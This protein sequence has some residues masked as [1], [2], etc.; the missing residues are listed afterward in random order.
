MK[1]IFLLFLLI[2]A[3]YFYFYSG[4]EDEM[5]TSTLLTQPKLPSGAK[6]LVLLRE[7]GL[8][9]SESAPVVAV[10]AKNK[11]VE[12]S[13]QSEL[14]KQVEKIAAP[15]PQSQKAAP[16]P[17]SQKK[18]SKSAA[19]VCF[20]LGPF[21]KARLAD[22]AITAANALSVKVVLRKASQRTPKGY[23]VY[24]A[25]SKT[26]KAA[27]R[28]VA[29]LKKKGLTDL[30]IMGNGNRKNAISLGLFKNKEVAEDRLKQVKGMGLKG[31]F[32][33][34]YQVSEQL[35]LDMSV[36]GNKTATVAALTEL[37]D[38]F[39]TANLTQRKCQLER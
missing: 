31:V 38:G 23:W 6:P 36:A 17:Q 3:A 22:R 21:T 8:R 7:R 4:A 13:A 26:Y 34:Q 28:K 30:F 5:V 35:W 32:E 10:Q 15:T 37:A 27:K 11:Q 19:A 2:N 12:P 39:P 16:T 24:L 20:T 33:T 1:I 18:P 29:E 14:Q 25:P 9:S